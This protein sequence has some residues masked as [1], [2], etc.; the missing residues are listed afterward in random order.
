M[1]KVVKAV[2]SQV[3]QSVV[4]ELERLLTLAKIGDIRAIAWT[5]VKGGKLSK[6]WTLP[7]GG[8]LETVIAA[9]VGDL[10]YAIHAERHDTYSNTH[11]VKPASAA[12]NE[13]G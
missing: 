7:G 8:E 13:N 11:V 10:F 1:N 12:G 5:A 2:E 9:G 6:G 3:V 4:D